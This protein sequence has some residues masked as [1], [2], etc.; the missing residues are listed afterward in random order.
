MS[1]DR[2][3]SRRA[4]KRTYN[5]R[6]IKRDYCYFVWEVAELF[7]LHANA[8]RRWLKVGLGALDDRRPILIHGRDLIDFLDGRQAR[9]KQKC[10]A[11]ELFCLRCRRPR[12]PRFGRVELKFRSEMRLDLSGVCDTCGTRMHRAGSV[13]RLEEYRQA[14]S[15]E[16]QGEGRITG[17][18]EPSLMCHLSG[19]KMD[20]AI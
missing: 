4:K 3:K 15:I 8:V 18:P 13:A 19:E 2:Q 20:A 7:D 16:M 11:D 1:A 10:A 14:F 17:C 6:L 5:T 12:H 9:R